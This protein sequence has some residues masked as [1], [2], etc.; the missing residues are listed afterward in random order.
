MLRGASGRLE[1]V[2][3][4]ID[5]DA[6]S[7]VLALALGL[8]RILSLMGADAVRLHYRTPQERVLRRLG[9]RE[10]RRWLAEGCFE[11]GSMAP[12]VEAAAAFVSG[13]GRSVDVTSPA[14]AL[15]ALEGRAGTRIEGDA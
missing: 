6:T 15:E 8:P 10:A 3:A 11:A 5:K 13:G 1:G 2:E 7:T 9:V 14:C 12:K 4:V